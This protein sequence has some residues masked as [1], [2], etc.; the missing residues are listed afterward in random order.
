M[1]N[2]SDASMHPCLVP[3]LRGKAFSFTVIML[4][5]GFSQMPFILLDKFLFIL[6]FLSVC[7]M[8]GG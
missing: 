7:F 6:S 5:V 4:A 1:L 3:A 8:K 2:P